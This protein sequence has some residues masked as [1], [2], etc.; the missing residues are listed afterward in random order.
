M[1]SAG[2]HSDSDDEPTIPA[3][4]FEQLSSAPRFSASQPTLALDFTRE[5]LTD[6]RQKTTAIRSMNK[7]IAKLSSAS[8]RDLA[9]IDRMIES[10]TRDL[11]AARKTLEQIELERQSRELELDSI[12]RLNRRNSEI[13]TMLGTVQQVTKQFDGE[14]AVVD[15]SDQTYDSSWQMSR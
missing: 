2:A 6:E 4:R 1:V 15:E 13:S 9:T 11:Q 3:N 14:A 5:K 10:K 8:P 7:Q 12:R